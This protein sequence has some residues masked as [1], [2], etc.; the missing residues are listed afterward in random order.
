MKPLESDPSSNESGAGRIGPGDRLQ[1]AR[2]ELSLSVD[3]IANRMHL[4]AAI[5]ESIEENDFEDITP[6][7]VKGYLRSYA[8]LVSLDE[9]EVIR[10]YAEFYSGEDPPIS[11]ISNTSTEISSDDVRIKWATVTVIAVLGGLLAAWWWNQ[12]QSQ[13]QNDALSL[14]VEQSDAVQVAEP[15]NDS[16]PMI[17]PEITASSEAANVVPEVSNEELEETVKAREVEQQVEVEKVEPESSDVI[18]AESEAMVREEAPAEA[19]QTTVAGPDKLEVIVHA[20][21]WTDI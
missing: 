3:D 17:E 2:I 7:F 12:N 5:L 11:S 4:S 14:A 19:S 13:N 20:D 18:Q 6:I 10:Q 21:T 9:E 8:R 15:V 16:S 1:A